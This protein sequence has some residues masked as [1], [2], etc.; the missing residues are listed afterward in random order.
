[1]AR[2]GFPSKP[3]GSTPARFS[4]EVAHL[5]PGRFAITGDFQRT[6]AL[7]I[8]R[9]QNDE[10]RERIVKRIVAERPAMLITL[11][12]HVFDGGSRRDWAWFDALTA[13]IR[14]ASIPVLPIVGNHECGLW[15]RHNLVHYFARFP[16]LKGCSW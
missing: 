3:R 9:E 6:S 14:D 5:E 13:P 2:S 12:D 1:M 7:E 11:G 15:G 16:N 8:G 10:E 4:A